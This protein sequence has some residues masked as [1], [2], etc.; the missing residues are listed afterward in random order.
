MSVEQIVSI[1]VSILTG[2]AT[3]IPLAVKLAQVVKQAVQEKNWSSV[4]DLVVNLMQEAET[5]FNDGATRKE[6]VLAMVQTSAQYADYPID[7][8]A[9]SNLIDSLC[10]LT[11]KVNTSKGDAK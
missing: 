11:N 8:A 7:N 3:C 6:W 4:L 5:K 1:I 10:A 9:L 2:A